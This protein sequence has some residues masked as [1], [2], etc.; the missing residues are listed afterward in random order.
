M[1]KLLFVVKDP[2]GSSKKLSYNLGKTLAPDIEL[3]KIKVTDI[4]YEVDGRDINLLIGSLGLN[5]KEFS[6]VY[7]KHGSKANNFA[8]CLKYL[9]V[10]FFDQA[11]SNTAIGNKLT[12]YLKL[13]MKGLPTIPSIFCYKENAKKYKE[14]IVNKLGFPIVTKDLIMQRGRGVSIIRSEMDFDNF[15]ENVLDDKSPVIFQKFI[16]SNEEYRILILKDEV[17]AYEKKVRTDPNEFRSNVSLGA[18]EEFMNIKQIPDDIKQM[19]FDSS[20]V[21]ELQISGVDVMVDG[22]GKKWLIEINR[23]PGLTYEG[24]NSPELAN[25]TA[26]FEKETRNA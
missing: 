4:I 22:D 15:V 13:S 6:L 19:S 7:F 1:K 5:V 20:K 23:G 21:L 16:E 11:V 25:I 8:L 14:H 10:K 26:F 3:T 9:G 17:G 24:E 12:D 2:E 18:T